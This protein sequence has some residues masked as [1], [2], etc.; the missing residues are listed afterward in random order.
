LDAH[1][2]DFVWSG[3]VFGGVDQSC[4]AASDDMLYV[5]TT[6]GGTSFPE[7]MRAGGIS[8]LNAATGSLVWNRT[9]GS[10]SYS[11]P[12]VVDGMVYVGSDPSFPPY[13][14]IIGHEFYALDAVTGNVVWSYVTDGAIHSSPA[15]ANGVVYVGSDDG[16]VYAFGGEQSASPEPPQQS[17]SEPF[18]T[19]LAIAS[20]II[21]AV[22]SVVL[23]VYFKKRK[24]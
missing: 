12:A 24:H 17:E 1:N 18:P 10:V 20:V 6:W 8:A 9:L 14:T 2:G 21:V 19:T 22:F 3:T 4:I 11:S 13:D 7:D 23:L 5:A 16:K 15:I